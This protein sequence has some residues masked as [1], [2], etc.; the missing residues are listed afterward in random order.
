MDEWIPFKEGDYIVEQAFLLAPDESAVL[1]EDAVIRVFEDRRGHRQ[2]HGSC[3]AINALLIKLL[4]DHN[5]IDL[6]LDLGAEFKYLLKDPILR[7]GKVFSPDVKS[8]L[9]FLPKEPWEQI[10]KD[11]F[12]A[13]YS[14]LNFLSI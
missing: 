1:L 2:M 8:T 12:E 10:Q 11:K 5:E 13:L 3:R 6:V 4:D 14:R 9:Q 7:G